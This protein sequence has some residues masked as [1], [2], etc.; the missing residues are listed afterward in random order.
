MASFTN[1]PEAS[2]DTTLTIETISWS[3]DVDS[4]GQV[5]YG[6]SQETITQMDYQDM[7]F[8]QAHSVQLT[9]LQPNQTYYYLVNIQDVNGNTLVSSP[10]LTFATV[11]TP[12]TITSGPTANPTPNSA[13][14]AWSASVAG[15]GLVNLGTNAASLGQILSDPTVSQDHA[16]TAQNLAGG[17]QYFYNCSNVDPVSGTVQVTSPTMN[18][19]TLPTPPPTGG[20][21]ARAQASCRRV[22]KNGTV[23][24]GVYL[25]K[26]KAAIPNAPVTFQ[27]LTG[28]GNIVAGGT[29]VSGTANTDA[30]GRARAAFHAAANPQHPIVF[31]KITSPNAVN[32]AYLALLI[33]RH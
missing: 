21:L 12:P 30:T 22:A 4:Y 31:I 28:N 24:I 8:T 19:T 9:G 5:F 14:I 3:A 11:A 2:V 10:N 6:P 27:V 25:F 23:Q 17:T 26:N 29:G 20:F 33:R 1:G 16:L 32:A 13:E 15:S 7:N 18:F